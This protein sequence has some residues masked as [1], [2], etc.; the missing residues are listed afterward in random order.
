[1]SGRTYEKAKSVVEAAEQDPS[2]SADIK[3]EMDRTGKVE[4]AYQEMKRRQHG[5]PPG[6]PVA[7]SPESKLCELLKTG[8]QRHWQLREALAG[9]SPRAVSKLLKKLKSQPPAGW[10]LENR[11]GNQYR[12]IPLPPQVAGRAVSHLLEGLPAIISELEQWGRAHEAAM[13]PVAIRILAAKL[14]K[15]FTAVQ[16]AEHSAATA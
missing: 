4:P 1:M 5:E 7:D 6:P 3:E 13:S 11:R 9:A 15:L 8:W 16:A 2:G 10:L 12:L 14:K